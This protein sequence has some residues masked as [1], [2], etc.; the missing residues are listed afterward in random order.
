MGEGTVAQLHRGIVLGGRRTLQENQIG[1]FG[2]QSI[3]LRGIGLL[4]PSLQNN[5]R[6]V[7]FRLRSILHANLFQLPLELDP[8]PA[9]RLHR[10]SRTGKFPIQLRELPA[11]LGDLGFGLTTVHRRRLDLLRIE[12][13]L[14]A[15][16]GH[17]HEV[18]EGFTLVHQSDRI[19]LRPHLDI[20]LVSR[21][22]GE[23]IAQHHALVR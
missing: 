13:H 20:L 18:I 22:A 8:M 23:E 21:T 15:R 12:H 11:S 2:Q 19:T 4:G 6:T 5:Q 16:P 14:L 10:K 9:D 1:V 3:H 7:G 17:D